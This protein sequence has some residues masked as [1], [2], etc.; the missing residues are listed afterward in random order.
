MAAGGQGEVPD[1]RFQTV[2]LRW[3]LC[4]QS[5][6]TNAPSIMVVVHGDA[7][8]DRT[9]GPARNVPV[10]AT[11]ELSSRLRSGSEILVRCP[12]RG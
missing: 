9:V 7:S 5:A 4:V 6:S 1:Q 10:A 3:P 11:D 12:S 2:T 8:A